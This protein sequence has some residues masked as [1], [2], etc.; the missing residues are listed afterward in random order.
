MNV[1]DIIWL[2]QFVEKIESKHGVSVDEV[3][4]ALQSGASIRRIERGY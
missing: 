4:E 1:T 3:E 2:A